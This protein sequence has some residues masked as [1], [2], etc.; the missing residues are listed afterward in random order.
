MKI[1]VFM[2]L[3]SCYNA[4]TEVMQ[5]FSQTCYPLTVSYLLSNVMLSVEQEKQHIPL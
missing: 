1:S 3:E 5:S 2:K 4:S